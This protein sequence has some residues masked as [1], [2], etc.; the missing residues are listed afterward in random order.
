M[1]QHL[2]LSLRTEHKTK[3]SSFESNFF[4]R[5]RSTFEKSVKKKE[6]KSVE[7]EKEKKC[8]K[9]KLN[10]GSKDQKKTYKLLARG[11][12]HLKM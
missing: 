12:W 5:Q 11:Q 4:S 8:Y 6:E 2:P 3:N 7:I 9:Q 1:L 10:C